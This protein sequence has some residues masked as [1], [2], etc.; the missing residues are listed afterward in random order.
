[1]STSKLDA[2]CCG[3]CERDDAL[4]EHENPAGLSAIGYRI[5]NY[6]RFLARMSGWI[7]RQ[8]ADPNEPTARERPLEDLTTRASDEP[9]IALMDAWA[10][11]LDVLTFYQERIATEGFLRTATERRSVLELARAISYEL[12]PGVAAST[13]LA[14]TLLDTDKAPQQVTLSEGL[15]IQSVPGP[16][17]LPQTFETVEEIVARPEWNAMLPVQREPHDFELPPTQLYFDGVSTGLGVGSRLLI[18]RAKSPVDVHAVLWTFL[19]VLDLDVD[20]DAKVTRVALASVSDG[21]C[22]PGPEGVFAFDSRAKVF[23]YS[24]P[25]PR[26]FTFVDKDSDETTKVVEV[27]VETGNDWV[28]F[29]MSAPVDLDGE[30]EELIPGS[31]LVF[32]QLGVVGVYNSKSVSPSGQVDFGLARKTTQVVLPG[33]PN[34]SGF[35]RRKVTVHAVSR[36]LALATKPITTAISG[37]EVVLEDPAELFEAGRAVMVV[38][39]YPGDPNAVELAEVAIVAEAT[40]AQ[41]HGALRTVLR[42]E[43]ALSNSFDRKQTRVLG[44]VVRATHGK[45]VASEVLGSGDGSRSFQAFAL[46]QPPLTYV[47]SVTGGTESTLTVR[48]GGVRWDPVASTYGHGPDE[49]IYVPRIDD[50]GVTTILFG[51]GRNGARL[52]TGTEN[53]TASYRAGL[54]SDGA[55]DADVLTILKTRPLGVKSVRNPIA[56][57]GAEDPEVF[58]DARTNAP[59]TVLTLDRLVSVRDYQDYARAYPGIGKAQAVRLWDGRRWWVHLTLASAEGLKV[60]VGSELYQSLTADIDTH[61]DPIQRV[62]FGTFQQRAFRLRGT[63][64]V[65]DAYVAEDVLAAV[66]TALRDAFAFERRSF[67]QAVSGAEILAIIHSAAG[68]IGVDLD[69]L[70][71][72]AEDEP[73]ISTKAPASWVLP[74]RA[75]RWTSAGVE[76]AEL[77]VLAGIDLQEAS[78]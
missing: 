46:R 17:E 48:V 36:K 24:A 1:M 73:P 64:V 58:A 4:D 34:L 51:D 71:F 66:S 67:G 11:V 15:Q 13:R 39:P 26:G 23:G 45:T 32:E 19:T 31:W 3:A 35:D 12:D 56:A 5:G 60:E 27:T 50:E 68:V 37:V 9:T 29:G 33:T 47:S 72:A 54:G 49:R 52:P 44:N 18:V 6:G 65:D 38:G 2:D 22:D 77:L 14:F 21:T 74:A 57:S 16:G 76:Q 69:A 63:V 30:I 62:I 53:V 20:K 75:A 40:Q 42:L 8:S 7:S 25:D 55:V 43:S 70:W 59:V 78:S 10:C 61:R 28:G 41:R